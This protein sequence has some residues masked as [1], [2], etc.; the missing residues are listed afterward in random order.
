L[1]KAHVDAPTVGSV[2]LAG[3]LLKVGLIGFIRFLIP[4]FPEATHFFAP[5]VSAIATAGVLYASFITLRQIDIKR[6]IAYSSVAHINIAIVSLCA[7]NPLGLYSSIYLI[8][9]H[10]LIA[11]GLF[12]L[13]GFLYTRFHVRSVSYFG[14]LATIIPIITLF[15]FLFSL[16]NMAFP[17]T[18]GFIGEFLLL[19]SI[20]LSNKFLGILNAT[21][22]LMTTVYTILLFGRVFL[23]ELKPQ[24]QN[25]IKL[26]YKAELSSFFLKRFSIYDL[27][28]YE[29]IIVF[30]LS[31]FIFGLGIYPQ[32][33]LNLL[34]CSPYLINICLYF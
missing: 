22:M 2:I 31:L 6:I 16:A 33:L 17:F 25:L 34:V 13:V 1:P 7:L 23:G 32:C 3:V 18:S 29:F 4:L 20:T 10:G 11:S 21:C 8:V 28:Y 5:Y 9:S 14:G 26:N 15:F 30:I 12:F 27:Y 19:L 24:F